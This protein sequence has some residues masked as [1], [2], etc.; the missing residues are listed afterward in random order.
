MR[1][2]PT[3]E[4]M[5]KC[6]GYGR[7][8]SWP[9]LWEATNPAFVWTDLRKPWK[10]SVRMT[11]LWDE[12]WIRDLPNTKQKCYPIG[13]DIRCYLETNHRWVSLRSSLH[14]GVRIRL[15]KS[16]HIHTNTVSEWVSCLVQKLTP[17][18]NLTVQRHWFQIPQPLDTILK[19]FHPSLSLTTNL[20]KITLDFILPSPSSSS[21]WAF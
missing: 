4:W 13:R 14:T 6:K 7:K 12:I 5:I 16:T 3:V 2:G 20:T 8:R 9:N 15:H 1:S 21:T 19:Q 17:C 11:G 18:Q 10:T